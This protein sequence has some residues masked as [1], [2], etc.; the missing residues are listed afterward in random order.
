MF[1]FWADLLLSLIFF[2]S[3]LGLAFHCQGLRFSA[4]KRKRKRIPIWRTCSDPRFFFFFFSFLIHSSLRHEYYYC[5]HSA[6][7]S[8]PFLSIPQ[9]DTSLSLSLC[10]IMDS[11]FLLPLLLIFLFLSPTPSSSSIDNFHQAWVFTNH[12]VSLLF[13]PLHCI[14]ACLV[15]PRDLVTGNR[16]NLPNSAF[17]WHFRS[18]RCFHCF[19]HSFCGV[20]FTHGNMVSHTRKEVIGWVFVSNN[21]G[22][23]LLIVLVLYVFFFFYRARPQ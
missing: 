16:W 3:V 12:T 2:F 10:I 1:S 9:I 19:P 7:T 15:F 13:F 17:C 4:D 5:F 6:S 20:N 23:M 11:P 18:S 8:I 14:Q 22:D 21:I